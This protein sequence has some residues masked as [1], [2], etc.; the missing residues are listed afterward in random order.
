MQVQIPWLR[1]LQLRR[2]LVLVACVLYITNAHAQ[3]PKFSDADRQRLLGYLL[4]AERVKNR[5]A[6]SQK[7]R[8]AQA[9]DPSLTQELDAAPGPGPDLRLDEL[10]EQLSKRAPRLARMIEDGGFSVAEYELYQLVIMFAYVD[11]VHPVNAFGQ[12]RSGYI[13]AA[14]IQFADDHADLITVALKD[15]PRENFVQ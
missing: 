7:L 3:N 9:V 13:S 12:P 8:A 11:T 10:A 15:Q 2:L 1:V 6:L 14:N 4:T 5:I